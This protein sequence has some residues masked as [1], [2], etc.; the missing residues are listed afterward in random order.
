[1]RKRIKTIQSNLFFTYS[2][3]IIIVFVVFVTFFYFWVSKLI[4]DKAFE[5]ISN[6]SD[7]TSD[8]LDIEIQK[9]DQI[10]MSVMYSSAVKDRFMEYIS[11]PDRTAY[12]LYDEN[13][14]KFAYINNTKELIDVLFA[15]IG[16]NRP[17]QQ[18]YLYGFNGK[19]FGTGT[20]NR[21][22]NLSVSGKS[23]YREVI[24]NNGKKVISAPMKDEELSKFAT[25]RGSPYF[26]SLYRVYF[27]NYNVPQGIVEVKQYYDEIFKGID[28]NI[29]NRSDGLNIF[30]YDNNGNIIYPLKENASDKDSHY[31]HLKD[32]FADQTFSIT[33]NNPF[34]NERELIDYKY[35]DYTGWT[36]VVVISESKLLS[37]VFTFTRIV[38]LVTL[39][40]LFLAL[41]FSFFAAKKVTVPIARLHK[42]IKSFNLESPVVSYPIDLPSDLY[43]LE[44]LNQAF[45]KMSIKLKE[46]HNELMFSQQQEMQARM[47]ALQSQMNPHFLYN[48]LTIISVMAEESMSEQIA[49]MCG[50]VSDML[51]YISSDK[52]PLVKISTEL[53][54]T[55][56]YL[57]CMKFR[58]GSKLSYSIEIDNKMKEIRIPKLIIQPL[59][60]NAIKYG[61]YR[62]PPWNVRIFGHK[63]DNYWQIT[64]EDN[65]TGFDNDKLNAI[66]EK[67]EEINRNGLIP[68]LELEGMGLLNIYIRL[69]LAYKNKM[70]FQLGNSID[71]GAVITIGGST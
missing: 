5:T 23:W 64:V 25:Q 7:S 34:N 60:E 62:E 40:T 59:A 45:H 71:G 17:V 67:I 13:N 10:S 28:R 43:E 29:S 47:L 33:A 12:T 4:K 57:S 30:V 58:Y 49:E 38:L 27:D 19:V 37:P 55:H 8:K 32:I 1:M 46:S 54:Y 3:I 15:I 68:S 63:T 14:Q 6:L 20:D 52:S 26:I 65:G 41:V 69:K 66:N 11:E 24:K 56:K 51:R 18:I 39:A 42:A 9:M 22:Q 48:T 70:I 16:P 61:T 53:E 50:N 31:F 2:L 36:T 21:Q 35:S 44:G